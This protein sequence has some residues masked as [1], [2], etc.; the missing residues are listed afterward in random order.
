MD[1][2]N[3]AIQDLE[4]NR[5]PLNGDILSHILNFNNS[6]QYHVKPCAGFPNLANTVLN[7]WGKLRIP[8]VTYQAVINMIRKL[9]LWYEKS[10]SRQKKGRFI[11]TELLDVLFV[12]SGC[13]CIFKVD[14]D[15]SSEMCN[16]PVIKKIPDA[17]VTFLLDQ[18]ATADGKSMISMTMW[19]FWLW[20]EIC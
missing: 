14:N 5:L 6:K 19:K 7:L 20:M 8:T 17:F 1:L 2:R 3:L 16:C 9:W 18:I 12:V 10:V 4:C 11:N 13:K 15:F